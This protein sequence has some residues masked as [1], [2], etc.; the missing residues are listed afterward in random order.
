MSYSNLFLNLVI[1]ITRKFSIGAASKRP[2]GL[3][4]ML[5]DN[6]GLES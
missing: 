4:A 6:A 2:V 1:F 5:I 3:T